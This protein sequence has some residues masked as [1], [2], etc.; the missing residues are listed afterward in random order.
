MQFKKVRRTIPQCLAPNMVKQESIVVH[1][2]SKL[3]CQMG[4]DKMDMQLR[5]RT[6]GELDGAPRERKRLRIREE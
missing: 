6:D 2:M 4:N 3:R 1:E 5:G